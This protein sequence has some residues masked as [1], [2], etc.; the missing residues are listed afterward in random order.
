MTLSPV[1]T[2]SISQN[3]VVRFLSPICADGIEKNNH[4]S[5]TLHK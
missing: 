2:G 1:R 5:L 4:T 3:A